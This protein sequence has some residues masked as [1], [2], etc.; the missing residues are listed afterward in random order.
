MDGT[1]IEQVKQFNYLG[2][3]LSLEGEPDFDKKTDFKT[4]AALLE[5][6][7]RKPVQIPKLKFCKVVARP[8]L[9]YGSETW[10]TTKRGMTGLETAEMRFPRSVKGYTRLDKIRI[11]ILRK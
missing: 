6:I 1:R 2:W 8:T 5:N 4:Y 11:E 7:Y 10:V 9:H 3:E